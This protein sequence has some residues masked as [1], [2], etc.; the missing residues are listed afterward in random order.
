[1][2]LLCHQKLVNNGAIVSNFVCFGLKFPTAMFHQS[3]FLCTSQ[4][5]NSQ[6]IELRHVLTKNDRI[7]TKSTARFGQVSTTIH[8]TVHNKPSQKDPN[9]RFFSPQ[10]SR[11]STLLIVSTTGTK[12]NVAWHKTQCT[13]SRKIAE[14][15]SANDASRL[16]DQ[17]VSETWK[18]PS[19]LRSNHGQNRPSFKLQLCICIW[20]TQAGSLHNTWDDLTMTLAFA[21]INWN[22]VV[23]FVQ[24]WWFEIVRVTRHQF[25]KVGFI[26]WSVQHHWNFFLVNAIDFFSSQG[27]NE[28][29]SHDPQ[30]VKWLFWA[31][32]IVA[33]LFQ[34]VFQ[35]FIQQFDLVWIIHSDKS[36]WS[37]H[38]EFCCQEPQQMTCL[39][40][41]TNTAKTHAVGQSEQ[42]EN[43]KRVSTKRTCNSSSA[44]FH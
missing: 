34:N 27:S 8:R 20:L 28:C 32:T 37:N 17:L 13:T 9:D 10:S 29:K 1:M 39:W 12:W 35:S 21:E 33:Q 14:G 24:I 7:L 18:L 4:M 3:N 40:P 42:M 16:S 15:L 36:A 38:H 23:Q 30:M 31:S 43:G 5:R 41:H 19:W 44:N 25:P 2:C 11:F 22:I 26:R 6:E